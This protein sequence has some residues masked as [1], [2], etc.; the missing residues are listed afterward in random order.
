M[1][2]WR[3]QMSIIYVARSFWFHF[4]PLAFKPQLIHYSF[5]VRKWPKLSMLQQIKSVHAV[6]K[7][8]AFV[9]IQK[10]KKDN[11][12]NPKNANPNNLPVITMI[13]EAVLQAYRLVSHQLIACLHKVW[14]LRHILNRQG[15]IRRKKRIDDIQRFDTVRITLNN[16]K[17]RSRHKHILLLNSLIGAYNFLCF[18]TVWKQYLILIKRMPLF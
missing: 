5:A 1:F 18:F 17:L 16:T 3:W 7:G 14:E 2:P 6:Q 11:H 15:T 9:T 12:Q 10:K 4:E 13:L 8:S